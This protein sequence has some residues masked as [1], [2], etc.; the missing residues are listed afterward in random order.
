MMDLVC[1]DL[2][3]S[4]DGSV[5]LNN[6]S[7]HVEKGDYLCIIGENGAG[8]STLMKG[9]LG[10]KK[11]DTGTITYREGTEKTKI[12]YLPQQN[13]L[14]NNFPA[15]CFEV[16]LTG[17]LGKKK[18]SMFYTKEEKEEA[19]KKMDLLGVLEFKDKRFGTLSGGQKQRVLL[20]RALLATGDMLLLDEPVTGLDPR[21]AKE[22]YDLIDTL[23]QENGITI[24]MISHDVHGAL[25]RCS[26]VLQLGNHHFYFGKV[27]DYK[28]SKERLL[29]EGELYE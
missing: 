15:S 18:R 10:L 14:Q 3:F 2:S 25:K 13:K 9:L 5:V 1:K 19:K 22:L 7:F 12:G 11:Q 26:H 8:K 17:C 20:A 23:N 21:I 6:V 29:F 16:V 28:E 27:E 4:Y 24:I